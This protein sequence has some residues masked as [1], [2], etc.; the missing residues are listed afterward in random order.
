VLERTPGGGARHASDA[1]TG[2]ELIVAPGATAVASRL[3]AAGTVVTECDETEPFALELASQLKTKR[4]TRCERFF[5]YA[6]PPTVAQPGA[7][8]AA[9]SELLSGAGCPVEGVAVAEVRG[10]GE[11]EGWI[12]T[13]ALGRPTPLSQSTL[14]L[15]RKRSHPLLCL[16][17]AHPLVERSAPL[18][19]SAPRLAA[20]LMARVLLVRSGLLDDKTDAYLTGW[21]LS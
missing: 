17:R 12:F 16:N 19:T 6:E 15:K 11:H 14:K 9:L 18:L 1:K 2:G 4:L 8:A 7:F 10:A 13:E 3:V 5:S 21:A 20:L